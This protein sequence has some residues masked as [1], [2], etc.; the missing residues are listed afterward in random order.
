[1]NQPLQIF[2]PGRHVS[3]GGSTITFS[4]AELEACARAYDPVKHEVPL[5]VGHPKH[6][7]PAY[8]W[9]KS[10]AFSQALEAEPH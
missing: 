4:A 9:V 3:S 7:D 1:M 6:D 10:L 8:G 5:T 2:R